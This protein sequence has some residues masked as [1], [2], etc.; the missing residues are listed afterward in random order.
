MKTYNR[1]KI[2]FGQAIPDIITAKQNDAKSRYLDVELFNNG[3]AANLTGQSVRLAA[4]K[5]DG[6]AVYTEG[7]VRDA[8]KGR[9]EFELTSETLAAV[10]MLQCEIKVYDSTQTEIL[11]TETF[12]IFVAEEMYKPEAAESTNE[13]GALVVLFQNVYDAMAMMKEMIDT[14]GN[15]G[16]I[17]QEDGIKTFWQILEKS[18]EM[19]KGALNKREINELSDFNKNTIDK[20]LDYILPEHAI[21]SNVKRFNTAGTFSW[22]CPP[23][24]HTVAIICADAGDGGEGGT[25]GYSG[26]SGVKSDDKT[27]DDSVSQPGKPGTAGKIGKIGGIT[28]F[29]GI[30]IVP[31]SE[32]SEASLINGR[33]YKILKPLKMNSG[34]V[35]KKGTDGSSVG[36][37]EGGAG[38][39]GG[40]G[41]K[42]I[43]P[44]TDIS[45]KA[46][47][48][49]AGGAGGKGGENPSSK[50]GHSGD[51]GNGG[52]GGNSGQLPNIYMYYINVVP[53]RSYTVKIGAGGLGGEGGKGGEP[54]SQ[55]VNGEVRPG[56]TTSEAGHNGSAGEKGADGF[57]DIYW[58]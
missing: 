6:N 43:K 21:F 4:L 35:G 19:N 22:I 3:V 41:G 12:N 11:T 45:W 57:L 7:I 20:K 23:D 50:Y 28:T 30:H 32:D 39:A 37:H 47:A 25:G 14:Y 10:G 27:F 51:G 31:K 54:V 1:L 17:S 53:G 36:Y 9:C 18:Y 16:S 40:V 58:W 34:G 56:S 24:V 33:F 48:G 55:I 46:G 44:Y 13:Y 8:E 52:R 42:G 26:Q 49:G 38:G 5:P 29:N 15:P 2:Q